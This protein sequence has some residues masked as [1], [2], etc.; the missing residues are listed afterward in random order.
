MDFVARKN[1]G[2]RLYL[3]IEEQPSNLATVGQELSEEF[4][5]DL[6][7]SA[8]IQRLHLVELRHNRCHSV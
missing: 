1:A 2:E 4:P 3:T 6:L 8:A 7:H 5:N